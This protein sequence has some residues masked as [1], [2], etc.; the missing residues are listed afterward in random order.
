MLNIT[1]TDIEGPT[2]ISV[3]ISESIY[4]D[5]SSSYMQTILGKD[6]SFSSLDDF[7]LKFLNFDSLSYYKAAALKYGICI[8]KTFKYTS[9]DVIRIMSNDSPS[10]SKIFNLEV[11]VP[12]IVNILYNLDI[13]EK[14]VKISY[15][16]LESMIQDHYI[17][18]IDEREILYYVFH[19]LFESN[20]NKFPLF[21]LHAKSIYINN[22]SYSKD[23]CL[24]LYNKV[25][26]DL[27]LK[28]TYDSELLFQ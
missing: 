23:F 2:K 12:N 13:L 27:N 11:S 5:I 26:S 16:F 25:K 20:I 3:D 15:I 4:A 21:G 28:G 18:S 8:N 6:Y 14:K 17:Q 24:N 10:S 22:K 1:I 9:E 19:K 7:V